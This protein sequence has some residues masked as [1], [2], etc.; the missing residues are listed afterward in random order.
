MKGDCVK[1]QTGVPGGLLQVSAA[2]DA[3]VKRHLGAI[4]FLESNSPCCHLG[5][6]TGFGF[7]VLFV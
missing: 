2:A 5:L 6:R 7:R 3:T 4:T 1:N